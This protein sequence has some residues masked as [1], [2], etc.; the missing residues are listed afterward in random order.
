[1]GKKGDRIINIIEAIS[2]NINKEV[3]C[4]SAEVL[5]LLLRRDARV[6]GTQRYYFKMSPLH[7]QRGI[8]IR[9]TVHSQQSKTPRVPQKLHHEQLYV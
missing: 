8:T 5:A 4:L 9:S 7:A 2:D 1:L 6:E 3:V